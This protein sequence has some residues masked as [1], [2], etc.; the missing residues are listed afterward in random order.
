MRPAQPVLPPGALRLAVAEPETP[1]MRLPAAAVPRADRADFSALARLVAHIAEGE[2]LPPR[3]RAFTPLVTGLAAGSMAAAGAAAAAPGV[4][5]VLLAGTP[6]K[7]DAPEAARGA[8]PGTPS[9]SDPARPAQASPDAPATAAA[10]ATSP[11]SGL[12]EQ[13]RLL[14]QHSGIFYESHLKEWVAGRFP[15]EEL[16][17]EPQGRHAQSSASEPVPPALQPLVRDQLAALATGEASFAFSPWPGQEA[18]L[19]IGED[20]SDARGGSAPGDETAPNWRA[21]LRLSLP[22]LGAVELRIGVRGDTVR[23][24]A[25]AE[26]P[27]AGTELAQAREAIRAALEA[28]ALHLEPGTLAA[29]TGTDGR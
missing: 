26:D 1:P 13:L 3:A 12:P 18:R 27:A 11:R 19:T 2:T 22:R 4:L 20:G 6:L 15:R 10:Q 24:D 25:R 21:T 5:A 7:A 8:P 29:A 9:A 16:A 17:A 23:L 28:R 14:V